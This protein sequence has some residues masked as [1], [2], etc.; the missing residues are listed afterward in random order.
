MNAGIGGGGYE[1]SL[2]RVGAASGQQADTLLHTGGRRH[3]AGKSVCVCE[4]EREKYDTEK[5]KERKNE[6]K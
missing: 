1:A 3:R 6:M 5:T 2:H 4:R